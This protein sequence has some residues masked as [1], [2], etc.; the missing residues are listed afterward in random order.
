M[1]YNDDPKALF[2]YLVDQIRKL[3]GT[4]YEIQSQY[5]VMLSKI[6]FS[7]KDILDGDISNTK[8]IDKTG[9]R[10]ILS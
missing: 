5:K 4:K 9:I 7:I 10:G 8:M 1:S 3:K 6:T 2:H